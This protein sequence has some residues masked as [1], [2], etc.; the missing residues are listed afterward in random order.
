VEIRLPD[1]SVLTKTAIPRNVLA[2][3]SKPSDT[4]EYATAIDIEYPYQSGMTTVSASPSATSAFG[5]IEGRVYYVH[6]HDK[7]W[8]VNEAW[9]WSRDHEARNLSG[10]DPRPYVSYAH[11]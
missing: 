4:P 1:G 9:Q 3:P 10:P 6:S 8:D 2:D 7:K 5:Y 11:R